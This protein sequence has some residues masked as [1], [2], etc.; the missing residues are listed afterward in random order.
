[1]RVRKMVRDRVRIRVR[2]RVRVRVRAEGRAG[3]AG[4]EGAHVDAVVAADA[5]DGVETGHWLG[6]G[7]G[8]VVRGRVRGRGRGRGTVRVRVSAE[9]LRCRRVKARWAKQHTPHPLQRRRSARLGVAHLTRV[10]ARV[11]VRG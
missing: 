9:D 7:L 2:V 3:V 10:R 11:R 8:S 5:L 1:M 6:L 4:G